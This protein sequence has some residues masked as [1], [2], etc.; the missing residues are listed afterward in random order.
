MDKIINYLILFL[1]I[2]MPFIQLILYIKIDSNKLKVKKS[3]ILILALLIY[4][5]IPFI[6]NFLQPIKNP[7]CL[8][9]IV[10]LFL[11]IWIVGLILTLS[12]EILYFIYRKLKK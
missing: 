9:P 1:I 2:L 4:F 3:I 7:K 8:L 12:V 11:G 10:S 6:I 5:L